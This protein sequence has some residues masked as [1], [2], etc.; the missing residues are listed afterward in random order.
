MKIQVDIERLVL[1][2]IDIPA[3]QRPLLQAAVEAELARLLTTGGLNPA[4]L[5]GGATPSL[6]AN[7]MQWSGGSNPAQLGRQIAQTVYRG[8]GQ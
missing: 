5:S 7:V 6:R 3:G 4:L 2:G 1:D 8:I